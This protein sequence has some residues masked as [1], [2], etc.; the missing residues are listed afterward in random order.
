MLFCRLSTFFDM[1]YVMRN[2]NQN[3]CQEQYKMISNRKML[4]SFFH[5]LVS[6]VFI[7]FSR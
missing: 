7:S 2:S 6:I 5:T 4:N 1:L 3:Y